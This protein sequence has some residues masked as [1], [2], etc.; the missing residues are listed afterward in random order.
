MNTSEKVVPT[1]TVLTINFNTSDFIDLLLE[2]FHQLTSANYVVWICDNGSRPK[3]QLRLIQSCKRYDNVRMIFRQQSKPGS[4]GHGEAMDL[5]IEKVQTPYFLVMDSDA[6]FLRK[7]WDQHLLSQLNEVVKGTGT[8]IVGGRLK[9]V[10]F[11]APYAALY[12][13]ATF[14]KLQCKFLPQAGNEGQGKDT[15]YQVRELFFKNGY[16]AA[17]LDVE[18]TRTYHQGSF[19]DILCAEYYLPGVRDK[20]FCCHFARGASDGVAKYKDKLIYKIPVISSL[21]KRIQGKRDRARWIRRCREILLA[22]LD[23]N[24]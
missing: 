16:K 2:S 7:N 8:P 3:D 4:V 23:D 9:H 12:E 18:N 11:P 20:I 10:D 5:L 6:V 14:K 21:I 15:G 1:L 13:T 24:E 19:K 17:V 22:S